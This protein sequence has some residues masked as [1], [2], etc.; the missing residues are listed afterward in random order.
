MLC[1]VDLHPQV[2]SLPPVN[3][4]AG[5]EGKTNVAAHDERALAQMK[6]VALCVNLR[7]AK[8]K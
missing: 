3:Y 8:I 4:M 2:V 5:K 7:K 6:A 1:K